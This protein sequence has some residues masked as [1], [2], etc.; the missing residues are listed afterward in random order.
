MDISLKKFYAHSTIL[1]VCSI[2]ESKDINEMTID[3]LQNS[4][5]I[6]E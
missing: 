5:L 3:E 6:H 2:E 4:L 1:I